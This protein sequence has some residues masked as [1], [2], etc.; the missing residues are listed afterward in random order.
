MGIIAVLL[1]VLE[2]IKYKRRVRHLARHFQQSQDHIKAYKEAQRNDNRH[3]I[4]Q[5]D[6]DQIQQLKKK[7]LDDRLANESPSHDDA[8]PPQ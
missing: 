2:V 4:N 7:A 6:W 8:M 1:V 3:A 5:R